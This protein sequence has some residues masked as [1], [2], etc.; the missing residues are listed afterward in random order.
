[1]NIFLIPLIAALIFVSFAQ[2]QVST[3]VVG[4]ESLSLPANSR[5]AVGISLNN[6]PVIASSVSSVD[7]VSGTIT[8]ANTTNVGSMLNSTQPYYL[9]VT[10]GL[11]SGARIDLNVSGTIAASNSTLIVNSSS[12]NNTETLVSLAPDLTGATVHIKKH[13][14]L[15]DIGNSITGLT[16]GVSG[17]GDEILTLD[18]STGGFKVYLRRTSTTWRDGNNQIVNNL[19]IPP[20]IGIIIAKKSVAGSITT[21]GVVRANNFHLNLASGYQLVASGYPIAYSPNSLGAVGTSS[22]VAAPGWTASANPALA[23]SISAINAAGGFDRYFL[24]TGNLWRDPNALNVNATEFIQ[25]GSSY[26]FF[27]NS[28]LNLEL[29]KPSGL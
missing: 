5:T 10:S 27:K 23:D 19:P 7:A 9:E 16:S 15:E 11:S 29:V 22:S 21:T 20:G 3:P 12:T 25:P 8:L 1:M 14:T 2:S 24:R 6:N 17:T 13:I 26:V 18:P 4:F 28:A